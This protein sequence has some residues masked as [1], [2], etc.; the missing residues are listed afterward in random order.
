[1][2]CFNL[3]WCIHAFRCTGHAQ[4]TTWHPQP[5]FRLCGAREVAGEGGQSSTRPGHFCCPLTTVGRQ[6]REGEQCH[7]PHSD[8]PPQPQDH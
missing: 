6:G 1:M 7:T 4:I 5:T 8:M 3:F 2:E